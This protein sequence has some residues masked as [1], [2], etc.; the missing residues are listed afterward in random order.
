LNGRHTHRY[1]KPSKLTLSV[2]G[3]TVLVAAAAGVTTAFWPAPAAA[4]QGAGSIRPAPMPIS[5]ERVVTSIQTTDAKAAVAVHA[6]QRRAARHRAAVRA[7]ARRAAAARAAQRAAAA[8]AAAARQQTA[9]PAP[10]APSGSPQQIAMSMLGSYGWP[11][12]QFSCL[13][14]L[15]AHESDWNVHASNP[16]GAYGIPQAMP[17]SK[18][19]TAGPAWES[20]A[21]TQI[22][23]GLDYIQG[24]YGSPCAAWEHEEADGWY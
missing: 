2:A 21:A 16:S 8:R 18:M 12:G 11:A 13:D 1:R 20:D 17:G 7:A 10:A 24:T 14:P 5:A 3:S 4:Q 23:W 6:A 22:R 9:T 15:W 19:A